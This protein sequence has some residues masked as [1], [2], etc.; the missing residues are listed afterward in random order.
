M[1]LE[2]FDDEA[3]EATQSDR[4]RCQGWMIALDVKNNYEPSGSPLP[5]WGAHAPGQNQ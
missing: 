2:N 5:A 3:L 1:P 4:Q